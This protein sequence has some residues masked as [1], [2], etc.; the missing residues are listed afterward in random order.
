MRLPTHSLDTID[1]KIIRAQQAG[2]LG[3]SWRAQRLVEILHEMLPKASKFAALVN[4]TN[5]IFM[6][7]TVQ[8]AQNAAQRLGL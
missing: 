2:K 1:I 4:P 6:R 5:P 8:G 3:R 7:D